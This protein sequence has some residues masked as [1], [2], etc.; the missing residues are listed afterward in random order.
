M[1]Q[2]Q[3]V[4]EQRQRH[5]AEEVVLQRDLVERRDKMNHSPSRL[6]DIT[7]QDNPVQDN[8]DN[9]LLRTLVRG[10]PCTDLSLYGV[11]H[12]RAGPVR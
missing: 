1:Q 4:A 2:H 6:R 7:V 10:S 11:V 12:V 8:P 5:L 3:A 9:G